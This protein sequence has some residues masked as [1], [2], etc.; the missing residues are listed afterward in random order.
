MSRQ[1]HSQQYVTNATG[2]K[3]DQKAVVTVGIFAV[4][5]N[6]KSVQVGEYQTTRGAAEQMNLSKT[7]GK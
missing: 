4:G 3:Y 5:R 7:P 1:Q 2:S 6:G